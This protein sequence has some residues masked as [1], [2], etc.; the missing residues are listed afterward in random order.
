MLDWLTRL[1]ALRD[2][3][4]RLVL[5]VNSGTSADAVDVAIVAIAGHG[6]STRA[7]LIAFH[8]APLPEAIRAH[9][10]L[11][12]ELDAGTV[13]RTGFDLGAAF[14]AAAEAA[15]ATA[16]VDPRA[17]DLVASH[18]QTLCHQPRSGL[19]AE[20]ATGADGGRGVGATLQIGESAVIAERLGVPVICDF[21]TRDVAAGGDGAPLVPLVDYLLFRRPGRVLAL[22]NIGGIANVTV[23]PD[24]MGGIFAFD[25][26]PGNMGLDAVAAAA[27]GGRER[28]DKDGARA[29]RGRIDATLLAELHAHPFFSIV[30]PRSS[31]REM[32]GSRFIDTL[33][34]RY[35]GRLDDLLATLTRFTAESI[36][37]A[38][39]EHVEPRTRVDEVLVSGGG[40]HNPVLMG[41]LADLFAPIPVGSTAA[42]GMDPDAKEAIAFAVLANETLFGAPGNVPAATGAAGPRILGKIVPP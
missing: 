27:S 30:P 34:P 18:G 36:R 39:R 26:G 42:A 14:A 37:R 7:R 40:V 20:A 33:L 8:H 22:Q 41:H 24:R 4:E 31:G 35:A 13:C 12:E 3:P 25:T 10:Q 1:L 38:Y 11:A 6:E 21:R 23:V 15:L 28:Y 5:G 29:A 16:G 32:F 17:V 19:P 2:K 9:V